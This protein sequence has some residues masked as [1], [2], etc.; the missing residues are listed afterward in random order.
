[1][2]VPMKIATFKDDRARYIEAAVGGILVGC[3][4][5]PYGNPQPGPKFDYKLTWFRRLQAH[6]RKL[7]REACQSF[8]PPTRCL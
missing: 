8:W 6:A 1:M 3:I 2:A 5:L 4:Y 7:L